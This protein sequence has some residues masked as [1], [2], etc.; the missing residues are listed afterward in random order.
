MTPSATYW[1]ASQGLIDE[2]VT[3]TDAKRI[4]DILTTKRQDPTR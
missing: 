3:A 1:A 4:K 2:G